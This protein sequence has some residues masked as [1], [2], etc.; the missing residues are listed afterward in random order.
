MMTRNPLSTSAQTACSREEPQPKFAPASK[1]DACLNALWFNTK[2]GFSVLV[3]GSLYRHGAN[4]PT[5]RP[6]LDTVRISREGMMVSVSMLGRTSG[7]ATPV[8]RVKGITAG[9]LLSG[10]RHR[11]SPR[12]STGWRYVFLLAGPAGPQNSGWSSK[13][14]GHLHPNSR[15]PQKN[16]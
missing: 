1:I 3:S 5:A 16:T 11:H 15:P 6:D 14:P 13:S 8:C 2:C 9:Y 12:W 10:S 7:A 4:S